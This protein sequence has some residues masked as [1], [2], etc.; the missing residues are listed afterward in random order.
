L[1][2][3]NKTINE[4]LFKT[5]GINKSEKLDNVNIKK[6]YENNLFYIYFNHY[7]SFEKPQKVKAEK[8]AE[9]LQEPNVSSFEQLKNKLEDRGLKEN[10][11]KDFIAS[12]SKKLEPLE[13]MRNAI[14]HIRNISDTTIRSFKMATEDTGIDKGIKTLISDFWNN[15]NEILKQKTFM[16]LAEIEIK[17][18]F[19]SSEM[20]EHRFIPNE[21]IINDVLNEE[22]EEL[23]ALQNDL[24][25]YI[26]DEINVMNYDIAE[27][28]YQ[29][30]N[31]LIE[32]LWN[33]DV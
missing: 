24:L 17:K 20:D 3:N 21:D 7:A 13:K 26:D 2:Y 15:E 28:D 27:D 25:S 14:M 1:T 29:E 5:F 23:E 31:L 8:I 9:F 11:H 10:R 22:Y 6:N 16:K 18:I 32:T 4:N 19:E 30:L 12:I 33:R